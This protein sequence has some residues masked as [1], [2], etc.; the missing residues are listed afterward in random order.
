MTPATTVA[1]VKAFE[2][3]CTIMGW[4]Q[5]AQNVTKF[6]NQNAVLIVVVKNYSQIDKATLKA[7]CEVFCRVGGTNVQSR[8]AQNNHMM[9]QCLK[10]SLTVAALAH[11]EP[12][13]SQYLFDGV[14]YGPLM[15]KII[16]RLATIDSV[17]TT[18]TLHANL[19]NLHIYAASVNGDIDL[20]NSYFNVNYS[21]ILAR[22]STVDDPIAKFFDAYLVVP[23][24]NF[25]QYMAK[26]QDDMMG[27]LGQT[28]CTRI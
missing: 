26:K 19:N 18:K 8:A 6:T 24:F 10:K 27:I 13:Q 21:Q 25:K 4:N 28:L 23:D 15:Y 9:A 7:G 5:G 16:M 11:L 17:V 22:G 14:E 12:Y 20:I 2:F 3:R 1:F